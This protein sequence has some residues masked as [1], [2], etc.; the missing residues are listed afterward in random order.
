MMD[1]YSLKNITRCLR[2]KN[3]LIGM[4]NTLIM[5]K[6]QAISIFIPNFIKSSWSITMKLNTINHQT[7]KRV[8]GLNGYSTL[9]NREVKCLHSMR[10]N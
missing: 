10:S 5:E 8:A 1:N 7:E 9:N 4:A 2:G 3:T 6:D